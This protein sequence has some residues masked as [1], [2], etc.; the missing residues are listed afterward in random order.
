M[1]FLKKTSQLWAYGLM[2]GTLGLSSNAL[3]QSEIDYVNAVFAVSYNSSP[4]TNDAHLKID[5]NSGNFKAN[6]AIEHTLLDTTQSAQFSNNQCSITPQSYTSTSKAAFR[7]KTSES[8]NFDWTTKTATRQH[9][10]DGNVSFPLNQQLY[11]PMSL[12]FKARCDLMA[13]KTQLSYPLIH[14]GKEKTHKYNVIGTEMVETGMGNFEA[15]V[16]Q[17]QRSNPDRRTTFYVAPALD[18]LIV[19]INHRENSLANVSM[20]LKSMDYKTK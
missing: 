15:L 17:R 4:S 12:F 16:V 13:G 14:K 10:K 11:D 5:N 7:S 20:T 2:I 3:A 9:N 19:K 8:L 18:Y 1:D 6:F